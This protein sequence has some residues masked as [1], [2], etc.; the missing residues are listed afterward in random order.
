MMVWI[1]ATTAA[2]VA[3]FFVGG[4]W[5]GLLFSRQLARLS[6]DYAD[7]AVMS[8]GVVAFEMIRCLALATGLAILVNWTGTQTIGTALLLGLL[9]WASFQAAG[10][11]GA[12]IHERYPSALYMIH[13]GDA[14]AKALVASLTLVIITSRYVG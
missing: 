4:L 1:G 5:Y 8:G 3:A 10:L 2:A 13:S 14:L 9:I 6:S 12:V 11:A 7:A